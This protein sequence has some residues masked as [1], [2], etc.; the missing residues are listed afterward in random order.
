L[1]AF[2]PAFAVGADFNGDGY[3]DALD[4]A[5]WRQ[6]YG[7]GGP[8]GD[9]NGDGFVDAADYTVWRNTFSPPP[10]SGG[11]GLAGGAVPEPTS[12]A[13]LLAGGLLALALQRR[14]SA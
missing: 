5:I 9:A 6:N 13:M 1:Q 11:G 14:R 4:Y 3:V 10:G 8:V 2:D 12:F 7:T